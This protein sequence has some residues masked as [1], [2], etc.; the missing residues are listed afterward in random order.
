[1]YIYILRLEEDKYYVGLYEMSLDPPNMEE[2]LY[3][4][5]ND[6]VNTYNP[7]ELLDIVPL[8]DSFDVNTIMFK[9]MNEFGI[10]N[11]RGGKFCNLSL[12]E[13]ERYV[14]AKLVYGMTDKCYQCGH[15][16]HY[17]HHCDQYKWKEFTKTC[18]ICHSTDHHKSNHCPL[19]TLSQRTTSSS[20]HDKYPF[21]RIQK[22]FTFL[23]R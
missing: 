18:M 7:I 13:D 4:I 6:W 15:Y 19:F 20:S 12:N 11:V 10:D 23:K 22:F 1:M 5:N 17:K 3:H 8:S 21:K 14:F 2:I 9:L 16:G